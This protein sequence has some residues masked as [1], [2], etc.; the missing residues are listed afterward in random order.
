MEI[1]A[2]KHRLRELREE[3]EHVKASGQVERG[4]R[5]EEEI[6]A[7][8]RELTRAV[9]LGGRNRRAASDSER[10]RLN[11]TRA[12]KTAVRLISEEDKS[13]AAFFTRTIK[14]GT[15]C[16]YQPD[17]RQPVLWDL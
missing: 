4:E 15:F 12:I 6:E 10:A 11:V 5:I 13:L 3:L 16:A 17:P 9:G 14:T 7:L 2:Y 8:A 1:P